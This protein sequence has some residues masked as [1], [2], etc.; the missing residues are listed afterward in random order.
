[1]KGLDYK[2]QAHQG[3]MSVTCVALMA[4]DEEGHRLVET[5][6]LEYNNNWERGTKVLHQYMATNVTFCNGSFML[7]M[8]NLRNSKAEQQLDEQSIL[9]LAN[10]QVPTNE[11]FNQKL[12]AYGL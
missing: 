3:R 10:K 1:M 4:K 9:D 8:A 7:R 6:Q 12:S 5:E 11:N 2:Y